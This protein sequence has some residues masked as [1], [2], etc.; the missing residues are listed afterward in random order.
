MK[1]FLLTNL[2]GVIALIS[3]IMMGVFWVYTMNGIPARVQ[4]LEESVS[5]IQQQLS[6]NTSKIDIMME[7]TKFIKQLL[8]QKYLAR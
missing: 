8:M 3:F 6:Q 2:S 4:A 1:Q 5:G 7:D